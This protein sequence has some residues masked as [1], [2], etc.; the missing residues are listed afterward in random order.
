VG[1]NAVVYVVCVS[2]CVSF[3]GLSEFDW[4]LGLDRWE[5]EG[6]VCVVGV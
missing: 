3:G 1:Q 2:V 6:G 4:V 5:I